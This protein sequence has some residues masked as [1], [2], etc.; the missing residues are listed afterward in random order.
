MSRRYSVVVIK[1]SSS[2]LVTVATGLRKREAA[3]LARQLD[4]FDPSVVAATHVRE[5][6]E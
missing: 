2:G 3:D 5:R 6:D 1:L 4:N